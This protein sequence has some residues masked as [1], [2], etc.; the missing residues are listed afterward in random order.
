MSDDD[1]VVFEWRKEDAPSRQR[2]RP[3]LVLDWDQHHA[4]H[5]DDPR[6]VDTAGNPRPGRTYVLDD[7][8]QPPLLWCGRC[9]RYVLPR[10]GG[11]GG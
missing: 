8:D 2:P 7:S 5:E 3:T 4:Q 10:W 6:S 9:R 11:S 1:D